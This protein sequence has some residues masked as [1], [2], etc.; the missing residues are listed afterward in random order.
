MKKELTTRELQIIFIENGIIAED[1]TLNGNYI[2]NNKAYKELVKLFKIFEKNID[3]A[4]D[5]LWPLLDP[6]QN[7][8]INVYT[9]IVAATHALVLK[10]YINQ[11]LAIL[12]KMLKN[13]LFIVILLNYF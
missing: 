9:N 4:K 1:A 7:Q 6:L 11:S 2:L 13:R 12:E 8:N 5:T 3:L 10:I